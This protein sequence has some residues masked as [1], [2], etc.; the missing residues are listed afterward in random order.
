MFKDY[1]QTIKQS[2]HLAGFDSRAAQVKMA[3]VPR[4]L[5]RAAQ[6]QGT[7]R[8]GAVLVM[9]YC[10]RHPLPHVV[11]TKRQNSLQYHP[12]QISFPGGHQKK[13]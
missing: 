5:V 13:K 2:L 8:I 12:G 11:L 10:R 9:L 7:P 6:K 4:E 3:P 1:K